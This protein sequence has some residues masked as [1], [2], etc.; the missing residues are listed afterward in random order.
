MPQLIN[1]PTRVTDTS[2]SILDVILALDTKLVQKVRVME[3]S[4]FS[5]HDLVYVVLRL[6]KI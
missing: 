6:K 5:D 3:S 2:T 1:T 4:I